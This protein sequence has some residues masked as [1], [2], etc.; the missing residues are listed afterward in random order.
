MRD[1]HMALTDV[2]E[3]A[4]VAVYASDGDVT[5]ASS[6]SLAVMSMDSALSP[7]WLLD[8]DADFHVTPC[9]EWFSSFSSGRLGCVRLAD[10]S[11]YDIQGAGDVCL[12]LPSGASYTLRHVRYVPGLS[13]S[14]ISVRQLQDSGCRVLLREQCFQVQCGSLVIA[15]GARCGLVYPMH[16]SEVRDGV[17]SC[18][19]LTC[20]RRE[21]RRVSFAS[22]LQCARA[23]EQSAV[24]DLSARELE[25]QCSSETQ[26]VSSDFV[27]TEVERVCSLEAHAEMTDM[28]F[29]DMLMRDEHEVTAVQD[30]SAVADIE[31]FCSSET[32]QCESD[33][34]GAELSVLQSFSDMLLPE[35]DACTGYAGDIGDLGETKHGDC[36]GQDDSLDTEVR[37]AGFARVAS[38]FGSLMYEMLI[39]RPDIAAAVGAFA[40][41]LIGRSVT[42]HGIQH[43]GVQ[44]LDR[45]LQVCMSSCRQFAEL[46]ASSARLP[47]R[48]GLL[49]E[50][51]ARAHRESVGI[52]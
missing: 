22:E 29:F 16:V 31:R 47:Q 20:H 34:S 46:G 42:D 52:G 38:E 2:G 35:T 23:T 7:Q 21:T 1:V 14:L 5:L 4:T 45:Y 10:G 39:S 32:Q 25:R 3:A 37:L 15:R 30:M 48:I 24:R 41:G 11:A 27:Q 28:E 51:H 26:Q 12:S 19:T 50:P 36:F 43:R 17:V 40:A 44:V 9:R 13:Q 18:T 33:C 8:G 49:L 6:V